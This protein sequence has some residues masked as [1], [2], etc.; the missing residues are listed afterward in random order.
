MKKIIALLIVAIMLVTMCSCG[1]PTNGTGKGTK[2]TVAETLNEN[3]GEEN[4]PDAKKLKVRNDYVAGD[5]ITVFPQASEKNLCDTSE[6]KIVFKGLN[7]SNGNLFVSLVLENKTSESICFDR[8]FFFVNEWNVGNA[9]WYTSKT[10]NPFASAEAEFSIPLWELEFR[11]IEIINKISFNFV[12]GGEKTELLTV[13]TDAKEKDDS[14]VPAG[15]VVYDCNGVR[16]ILPESG[17]IDN[18]NNG[19]CVYVENNSD[20]PVIVNSSLTP[21]ED[22]AYKYNGKAI[23]LYPH[24]KDV[25]F[26]QLEVYKIQTGSELAFCTSSTEYNLDD[27]SYDKLSMVYGEE[28]TL[29]IVG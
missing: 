28:Y 8:G 18:K 22:E 20:K 17:C 5:E 7:Y 14:F 25:Y 11:H 1:A 15:E 24:T 3:E 16:A 27:M 13:E 19:V 4:T 10:V 6:Y 29:E 2:T 9:V 21:P 23:I 12:I 26:G